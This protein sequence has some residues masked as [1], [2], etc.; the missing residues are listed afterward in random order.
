ME[1]DSFDLDGNG[2]RDGAGASESATAPTHYLEIIKR[3]YH[4]LIHLGYLLQDA[5]PDQSPNHLVES[6]ART[7][8]I[9]VEKLV[10]ADGL[11]VLGEFNALN[12]LIAEDASHG[13][14]LAITLREAQVRKQEVEPDG[15]QL[16][17]FLRE[18]GVYDRLKGRRLSGMAINALESLGLALL[19]C[20]RNIADAEMEQLQNAVA[21]WR[22]LAG[23]SGEIS[24]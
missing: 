5:R 21:K 7:I 22:R 23:V 18:C 6:V 13:G 14:F 17:E 3:S 15:E 20:D 1:N 9:F 8:G 16:P 4:V 24:P 19:A 12:A 10:W 11:L 2:A